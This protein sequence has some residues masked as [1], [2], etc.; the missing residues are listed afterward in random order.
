MNP[1]RVPGAEAHPIAFDVTP[2][3]EILHFPEAQVVNDVLHDVITAVTLLINTDRDI[4]VTENVISTERLVFFKVTAPDNTSKTILLKE[5]DLDDLLSAIRKNK[6]S[7]QS[8]LPDGMYEILVQEPGD[9]S[10]R[11]VLEFKIVKGSIDDGSESTGDPLPSSSESGQPAPDPNS[12]EGDSAVPNTPVPENNEIPNGGRDG[13]SIDST[14][15][16]ILQTIASADSSPAIDETLDDKSLIERAPRFESKNGRIAWNHETDANIRRHVGF[17]TDQEPE[18]NST[19]DSIDDNVALVC[20]VP[21]QAGAA[22][23][24]CSAASLLIGGIS[25]LKDKSNAERNLVASP[26]LDR[27]ARLLRKSVTFRGVSQ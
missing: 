22:I 24:F 2:P 20:G 25:R 23:M 13:A 10:L 1:F 17:A 15:F 4:Q 6:A 19:S 14:I 11:T 12:I 7:D 8:T 26:R 5:L 16:S 18:V 27:A 21:Y 9:T 3:V